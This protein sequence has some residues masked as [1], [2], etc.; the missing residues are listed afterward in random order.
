[1]KYDNDYIRKEADDK[2]KGKFRNLFLQNNMKLKEHSAS[3]GE[4]NGTDFYFDVANENEEHIFFF[5]NQNKGTFTDLQIIK[6]EDDINY[7]KISH[8]ISLRNAINYYTE[9]DEAIIFTICDLE[10]NNIYW[11]DIQNDITLRDRILEQKNNDIDAIQIYIPTEN[12]LNENTFNDFLN[13]I[14]NAK[15]IQIR[16]KNILN[17][18][19]E[20]DYSKIETEISEKH[21]ID[22]IDYILNLFDGIKVFPTKVICKLLSFGESDDSK[23]HISGFSFYTY[24]EEFFSLM[25]KV[26]LSN[27]QFTLTDDEI[28]VD[29]QNEKI[30]SI[31][32]FLLINHIHHIRWRGKGRKEQICV[33]K[34]FHYSRC[35][36]ERCNVG[37]LDIKKANELLKEDIKQNTLYDILRKGYTQYL[38]GDYKA[39]IDVFYSIYNESDRI[40]NPLKYTILTYNL[41]KLKKFVKWYYY[42]NDEKE[43]S[44]KLSSINFDIDEPFIKKNTPYF[45]EIFRD[46]K[47]KKFY[48]DV[49]NSIDEC[50]SEIQKISFGDKYGNTY[51]NSKY[52]ILKSSY[53]RFESYL[54]HNFI[55]FNQYSEYEELSKK[56]LECIFALYTLKNSTADKYEK[57]DWSIMKMWIFNVDEK[58]SKYLLAKY[59]VKKLIIDEQLEIHKRIN[60]LVLNLINSNNCLENLKG[61][62]KPIKVDKIL[63]KILII[64]SLLNIEFDKKDLIVLN[65]IKFSNII[66]NKNN[67]PFEEL[68]NFI[69]QNRE[70]ISKERIKDILDLFFYDDYKRY[71]FG[72]SINI[73]AEKCT[74]TELEVFIKKVL[75]IENLEEIEI[76][77]ENEYFMSL[78]Y[79]FTLLNDDFKENIKF[80][81]TEILKKEFDDE[82]YGYSIVYDLIDFDNDLFKK[83]ISTVPDMSNNEGKDF[84]GSYD[85][86]RLSQIINLVFKFNLVFDEELRSLINKSHKKYVEYYCWLMDIDNYD[87]S[88]FDPYWILE[89]KTIYYFNRFKKSQKLK[90]ELYKCLN[91]NYIEGVAKVYFKNFT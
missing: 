40:N 25:E 48:D 85:N 82:L 33:H 56:I 64:T 31:V 72:R 47:E 43:V 11:Y 88:K 77:S 81:I 57:F 67:I 37:R 10:N 19:Y 36:C 84:W 15:L 28:F 38:L 26:K 23:S 74:Q 61:L 34:L 69:E 76:D 8:R 1:M 63:N 46:I 80:K 41:T 2:L 21:I 7:G 52:D 66:E 20:A 24:N 68:I 9:F 70:K 55:I 58:H 18:N 32:S 45:L 14:E 16:K 42:V 17:E 49:R 4:D 54:E 86:I 29:N 89:H 5:R 71:S 59:G 53:L 22:K 39:S 13:K 73:Y 83:Y 79:P 6:N 30:K 78:F 51:S 75:K 27:D 87:Y 60:E 12:I 91:E 62:F 44:Q 3:A 65:I 50:Y 35:N 90:E